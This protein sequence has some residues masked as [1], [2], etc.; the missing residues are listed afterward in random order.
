MDLAFFPS[1]ILIHDFHEQTQVLG[2]P[3]MEWDHMAIIMENVSID[4]HIFYLLNIKNV[5]KNKNSKMVKFEY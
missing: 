4:I 2:M 1:K 5:F 3:D